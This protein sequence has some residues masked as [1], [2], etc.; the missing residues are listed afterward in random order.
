MKRKTEASNKPGED[1]RRKREEVDRILR[2]CGMLFLK[3]ES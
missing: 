2:D 3:I 1:K